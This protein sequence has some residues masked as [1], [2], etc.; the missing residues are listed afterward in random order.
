MVAMVEVVLFLL[1]SRA[2][3]ASSHFCQASIFAF[4]MAAVASSSTATILAAP[5]PAVV[6]KSSKTAALLVLAATTPHHGPVSFTA[7]L[8]GAEKGILRPEFD[9]DDMKRAATSKDNLPRKSV[10]PGSSVEAEHASTTGANRYAG[11]Q[12][13]DLNQPGEEEDIKSLDKTSTSIFLIIRVSDPT[14]RSADADKSNHELF[15][16]Y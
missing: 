4:I 8:D 9:L 16:L 5:R 14:C 12:M 7:D 1:Y 2:A 13:D 6:R 11:L 15:C 10:S 3:A